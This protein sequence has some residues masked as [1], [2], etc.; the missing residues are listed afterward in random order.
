[1]QYFNVQ[2]T[3]RWLIINLHTYFDMLPNTL[4]I[5]YLVFIPGPV[6]ILLILYSIPKIGIGPK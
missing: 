5:T 4:I 1:M 3:K 6:V 2:L